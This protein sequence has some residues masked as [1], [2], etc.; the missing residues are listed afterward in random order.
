MI[1]LAQGLNE[2]ERSRAWMGAHGRPFCEEDEAVRVACPLY[3]QLLRWARFQGGQRGQHGL[4][5][6][7]QGCQLLPG[8]AH[9]HI[10]A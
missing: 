6:G 4:G 1:T 2:G 10:P 5:A 7:R 8:L 9:L 3:K